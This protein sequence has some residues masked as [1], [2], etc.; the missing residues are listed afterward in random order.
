[1]EFGWQVLSSKKSRDYTAE[2]SY[3]EVDGLFETAKKK[4]DDGFDFVLFGHSH[5]RR[6]EIYKN[7]QY[8]NLGTWLSKPCYAKFEDD[9]LEIIDWNNK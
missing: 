1:M 8:I 3:G 6:D 4:I 7:G 5:I 9:K 2:K